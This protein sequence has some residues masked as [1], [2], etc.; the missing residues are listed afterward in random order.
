M[1]DAEKSLFFITWAHS[2]LD[3][4]VMTA[5]LQRGL[6]R[7]ALQATFNATPDLMKTDVINRLGFEAPATEIATIPTNFTKME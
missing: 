5:E 6:A 1:I 7:A 2:M 4:D 3:S